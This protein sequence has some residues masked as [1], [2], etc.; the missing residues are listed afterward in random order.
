MF[1][2]FRTSLAMVVAFSHLSGAIGFSAAYAVYGF[3]VLSGFIMARIVHETYGFHP[4]G[5][6]HFLLNRFLRIYPLY[7][8]G[9]LATLLLI[10][11]FGS[12]AARSFHRNFIWPED[13]GSIARAVMNWYF[14]PDDDSHL[15]P[16]SWAVAVEFFF[17]ILIGLGL[18]RDRRLALAWLAASVVYHVV[19]FTLGWDR[20]YS[21][22]SASL[23]FSLGVA[24]WHFRSELLAIFGGDSLRVAVL[25]S[26]MAGL[27]S[28]T[29]NTT[30]RPDTTP[31]Y[32]SVLICGL[33]VVMLSAADRRFEAID[34]WLGR[35]SYP[36]YIFHYHVGMAT[37]AMVGLPNRSPLTFFV[38]LPFLLVVSAFAAVV[39]FHTVDKWRAVVRHRAV[40]PGHCVRRP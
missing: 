17:Y 32:A 22:W 36:I 24:I 35:L 30:W 21:I 20:Y 23:A 29:P 31:F 26:A 18:G 15:V 34:D 9:C 13:I 11:C 3:Y 7:W 39:Q 2:A 12:D 8:M 40:M 1:G 27:C 4:R 28:I 38:A 10:A 16:P 6:A 37:C 14:W 19:A 33:L 25:A 5:F